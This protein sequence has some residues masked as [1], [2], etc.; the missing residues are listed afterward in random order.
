MGCKV[1]IHGGL[2]IVFVSK[3]EASPNTTVRPSSIF[4]LL[5]LTCIPSAGLSLACTSCI[6]RVFSRGGRVQE[7]T[8]VGGLMALSFASTAWGLLSHS[9]AGQQGRDSAPC[10]EVGVCTLPCC[11]LCSG[12]CW[13]SCHGSPPG[14]VVSLNLLLCC[15]KLFRVSGSAKRRTGSVLAVVL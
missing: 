13:V 6:P 7:G 1:S 15:S 3:I 10:T 9:G 5:Q 2:Q 14:P 4:L 8:G 11:V 12:V